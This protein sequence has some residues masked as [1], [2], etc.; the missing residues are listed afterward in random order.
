MWPSGK[1]PLFG[2]GIRRFESYHPSHNNMNSKDVLLSVVDCTFGYNKTKLFNNLSVTVHRDD[3]IALVGKNGAGKSSLFNIFAKKIT[4]DEGEFWSNPNANIAIMHQKNL[5]KKNIKIKDFVLQAYDDENHTERFK[6]E[7]IFQKLKLDWELDMN[8]L[9]GGQLRKLSL[10]QAMLDEP[11]LL[12]LD[13]PT[14]HLDIESIKWLENFLIKEFKG[15]YL[16]I[17]HNR[18]FLRNITN[19]VFWIDRGKVKVSPKGFKFF[20]EWKSLLLQHEE[21]ELKNKKKVLD[22]ESD[23]LSKG[24]KAR[25]KRNERRKEEFFSFKE[26]YE[27]QR[28]DFIKTISKIQIPLEDK[29][30][31]NGPNI[32][33]NFIN[34]SKSFEDNNTPKIII[35]D[36]SFKLMRNEKIG[37][38]GKNGVGKSSFLK[39]ISGDLNFDHGKIKIK[40][41]INFSFFSQDAENFDDS[42]SIKQNL[43]PSGGDYLKVGEKKIHICSYLKN[44]L[45]DPKS[46]DNKVV[47]LSGGEKNRLLLS[48]ILADPKEIILLDEPT[49]DLDMETIDIMID[50]LKVYNGGVFISSHDVDFLKETC[51]KFI[52]LDGNGGYRFSLDIEKDLNLVG[53]DLKDKNNN[54]KNIKATE[55]KIKPVSASKLIT[56]ILKKIENKEKEIKKFS[57]KIQ[58]IKKINYDNEDYKE[59]IN[60]IKQAQNDL[61]LLEKEWVDL[62]EKNFGD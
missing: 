6:I 56:Q 53:K 42:K 35:K 33:I 34:V 57:E 12:L 20:E 28:S 5:Q 19:K 14:N 18:D 32:L 50:F 21:R 22:N 17:S 1:A 54:E 2:S 55:Q 7:N 13:E 60:K 31:N 61:N 43:I 25:R 45:F 10:I 3:K 29:K 49:N 58:S 26:N 38:I 30:D 24:V 9:S 16:V 51:K 47:N 52:F 44:F 23:W 11:D 37:I 41:D 40:K 36:F 39:M 4:V 62:E 48:K 46:V 27:Q 59:A 15:S 8:I